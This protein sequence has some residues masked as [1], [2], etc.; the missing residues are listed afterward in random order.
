MVLETYQLLLLLVV[1]NDD[2][3]GSKKAEGSVFR[4][5]VSQERNR[6]EAHARTRRRYFKKDHDYVHE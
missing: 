5:A 2:T 6:H 1:E 4:H 3:F